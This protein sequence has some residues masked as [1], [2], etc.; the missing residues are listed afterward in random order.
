MSHTGQ[1]YV[2]TAPSGAGKTTL[3][4]N[5]LSSDPKV[6]LSVSL[7]TRPGRE[8]EV[9]GVHYEFVDRESFEEAIGRGEFVEYARVYGEYYGTSAR[10][11]HSLHDQG[12]DVLLEIDWQGFLQVK[13]Y[14][15]SVVSVFILPPSLDVLETRL[16]GR[17]HGQ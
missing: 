9:D 13:E 11:L 8:G 15:A 7:T 16:R 5:L 12:Y 1:V 2:V 14:F 10:K 4:R 3:V 6:R 17:A